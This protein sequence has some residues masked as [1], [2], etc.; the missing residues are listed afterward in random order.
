VTFDPTIPAWVDTHV[1]SFDEVE[2]AGH[3]GTLVT[4][5]DAVGA[6]LAQVEHLEPDDAVAALAWALHIAQDIAKGN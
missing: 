4:L 5:T 6:L 3:D 1:L 2:A